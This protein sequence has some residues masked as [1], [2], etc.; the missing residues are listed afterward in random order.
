[1]NAPFPVPPRLQVENDAD[2]LAC[3]WRGACLQRF[4]HA[5]LTI[6]DTLDAIR[7]A[8]NGQNGGGDTSMNGHRMKA[9]EKALQRD[10]FSGHAKPALRHLAAFAKVHEERCW[11][12]HG[13][14]VA[15]GA[16]YRISGFRYVGKVRED[17]PDTPRATGELMR[18]LAEIDAATAR[19]HG[20]LGQIR[21]VCRQRQQAGAPQPL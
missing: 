13:R 16:R 18:L 4:A 21:R 9:L 12:A 6:A 8:S 14:F 20:A 10:S 19:L 3:C 1:M 7:D 11:I 17:Y 5:E 2:L 15:D